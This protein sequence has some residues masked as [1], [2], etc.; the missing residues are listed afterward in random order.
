MADR[1]PERAVCL[2]EG[3]AGNDQLKTNAVQTMKAKGITNFKTV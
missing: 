2:D 3:F 1:K